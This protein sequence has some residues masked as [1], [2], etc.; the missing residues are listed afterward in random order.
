MTKPVKKPTENAANG[1]RPCLTDMPYR[2]VIFSDLNHH[3][4][5][6]YLVAGSN[7]AASKAENALKAAWK[8]HGGNCFYCKKPIDAASFTIDHAEPAKLG[9]SDSIQNL[10]I[11]HKDCNARKGHQP[12]EAFNAA[13]G[14]E[15]LT[16][17]L[18]QVQDRLNRL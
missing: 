15:W 10:L 8:L 14:K 16:A 4:I 9:G 11:A 12:I 13:A 3:R 5:P 17:L 2:A 1:A 6:L 18:V 7:A